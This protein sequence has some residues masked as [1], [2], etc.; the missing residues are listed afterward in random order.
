MSALALIGTTDDPHREQHNLIAAL[1]AGDEG[2]RHL[3]KYPGKSTHVIP[4]LS[5]TREAVDRLLI[6]VEPHV[7]TWV[8]AHPE[9]TPPADVRRAMGRPEH[10]RQPI[11]ERKGP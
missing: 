10:K 6:A 8:N 9:E 7:T 1:E 5:W 3:Y 2:W 11:P 4:D